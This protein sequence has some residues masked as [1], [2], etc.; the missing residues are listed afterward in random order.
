MSRQEAMRVNEGRTACVVFREREQCVLCGEASLDI[1]RQG[2]FCDEPVRT[3]MHTYH[4]AG[5]FDQAL[6][7]EAFVRVQCRKCGISF[8]RRVLN[9]EWISTLYTD[10]ISSS[11]VDAFEADHRTAKPDVAFVNATQRV[12]HLLR[13]RHLSGR[14]QPLKLLDF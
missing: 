4:Y 3:W 2:R 6:E 8:H 12:K 14:T 7:A 13:L 5:T 10:W 9:E 11:Q 1:L